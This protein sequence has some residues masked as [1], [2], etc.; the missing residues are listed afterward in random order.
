MVGSLK[1][2]FNETK[3][4]LEVVS[5]PFY[6]KTTARPKRGYHLWTG[7]TVTIYDKEYEEL[8]FAGII[9]QKDFV[10][11][12]FMPIYMTPSIT[13][14]I[15]SVLLKLLTGK[16]CF[17][18]KELTPELEVAIRK[19]LKAGIKSYRTLGWV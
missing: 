13:H 10:G 17:H 8:Y 11:F 7:K 2:T 19:T 3:D 18:I 4:L 6:E 15:P 5:S 14:E 9:E 16:S 1:Q 12:Y